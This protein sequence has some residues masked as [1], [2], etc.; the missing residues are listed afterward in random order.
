MAS[1]PPH[2]PTLK[3]IAQQLG[4]HHSL[5]SRVLR[6]SSDVRVSE[7]KRRLILQTADEVGY[8]PNRLGSSL[9]SQASHVVALLSPD[10]TNPFHA[11]LFSGAEKAAR[12]A[13]Y[14]LLLC[15]VSDHRD[16]TDLADAVTRGLVD[17]VLVACAWEPDPRLALLRAAQ[18]PYVLINRPSGDPQDLQFLPDDE[19][20]ALLAAQALVERG[21]QRILAIFSDM[22]MGSMRRRCDAFVRHL[23]ALA[24]RA[25]LSIRDNVNS[26]EALRRLIADTVNNALLQRPT[27][28]FVPHSQYTAIVVEEIT[29]RHGLRVPQDISILGYG[30]EPESALSAVCV[31]VETMGA[32]GMAALLRLIEGEVPGPSK[33]YAPVLNGGLSL[34]DRRTGS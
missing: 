26:V 28:I 14:D 11:R 15:H 31:P 6:G 21:H 29:L 13:G 8:R 2:K 30:A 9:R 23:H 22:R 33:A 10:I 1:K 34:S 3:T 17:G 32:E 27:A 20:T 16:S 18:L 4:L 7:E 25:E 24:P 12:Q 5:I 19:A